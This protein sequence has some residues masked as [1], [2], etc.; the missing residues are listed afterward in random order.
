MLLFLGVIEALYWRAPSL[1][2]QERF[3]IGSGYL[4]GFSFIGDVCASTLFLRLNLGVWVVL[5]L[6]LG[7]LLC[8][9]I[10]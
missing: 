5:L 9:M 7:E 8:I 1:V 2:F 3:R 4:R 10:E 6:L